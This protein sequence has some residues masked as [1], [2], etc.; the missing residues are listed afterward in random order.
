MMLERKSTEAIDKTGAVH[1][2]ADEMKA[3]YTPA[4][5]LGLV[6]LARAGLLDHDDSVS[7]V[8]GAAPLSHIM[9]GAGGLAFDVSRFTSPFLGGTPRAFRRL[10]RIYVPNDANRGFVVG[11][12]RQA[13]LYQ[14]YYR[15]GAEVVPLQ[16][17][18]PRAT[19]DIMS[20]VHVGA[21]DL[22]KTP[23]DN[24]G[25]FLFAF[26]P[27]VELDGRLSLATVKLPA[28]SLD[29]RL[30][31][32]DDHSIAALVQKRI[33]LESFIFINVFTVASLPQP[34]APNFAPPPRFPINGF[35]KKR[36]VFKSEQLIPSVGYQDRFEQIRIEPVTHTFP[37]E[38][39]ATYLIEVGLGQSALCSA[40]TQIDETSRVL[41]DAR[42]RIPLVSVT[43][44]KL[45]V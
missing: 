13:Y 18:L 23:L 17:F 45:P 26:K 29:W 28:L 27:E 9:G 24:A 33:D 14:Q 5:V 35:A 21:N 41:L 37:A 36:A 8:G 22:R 32:K 20:L 15:D 3:H 6:E 31:V 44:D 40:P 39:G 38:A 25:A 43:T 10:P 34:A 30:S 2:V 12:P 4:E 7:Y 16:G 1:N 19:G 42:V 11:G